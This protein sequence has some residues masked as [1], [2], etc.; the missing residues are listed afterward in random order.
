MTNNTDGVVGSWDRVYLTVPAERAAQAAV[1]AAVPL[2]QQSSNEVVA[3][4]GQAVLDAATQVAQSAPV[5]A[6]VNQIP[7]PVKVIVGSALQAARPELDA[8]I[9]KCNEEVA[10]VLADTSKECTQT[11]LNYSIE[12]SGSIARRTA[13]AAMYYFDRVK[14]W[15]AGSPTAS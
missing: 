5:T 6:V 3:Q 2:M 11:A 14:A 4:V 9:E 7:A 1:G 12:E 15:W 8:S 13:S 10:K